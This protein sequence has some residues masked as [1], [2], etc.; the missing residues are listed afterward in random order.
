MSSTTALSPR[1][2]KENRMEEH[3]LW[4]L[5]GVVD[6][7]ASIGSHIQKDERYDINYQIF[8]QIMISRSKSEEAIFGMLDE[9]CEEYG[10]RYR[11]DETQTQTRLVIQNPESAANFLE[12]VIGGLIQ[13]QEAA[14]I[15]LDEF[16][17]LLEKYENP[18]KQ[19]FIELVSK[20]EELREATS[21]TQSSKYDPEYFRE[22]WSDEL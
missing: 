4:Y 20:R 17:P 5:S 22:L 18:S 14:E 21:G 7:I 2:A 12:P 16:L 6:S 19:E 8:S 3:W 1:Q 10:V 15:F 11:I 9:Y 13:Q